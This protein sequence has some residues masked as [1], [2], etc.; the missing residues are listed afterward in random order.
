[1]IGIR[2]FGPW[3]SVN[4]LSGSRASLSPKRSSWRLAA[5]SRAAAGGRA[6]R[7]AVPE[8]P[9]AAWHEAVVTCFVDRVPTGPR[10]SGSPFRKVTGD[11][12]DLL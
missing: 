6:G 7:R 8:I 9:E 5:A 1:M 4:V 3:R 11:D 2:S 10:L 12:V